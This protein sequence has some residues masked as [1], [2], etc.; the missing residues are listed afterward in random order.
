MED[1]VKALGLLCLGTRMKRLGERLQS[2]T[3]AIVD[4]VAS[5]ISAGQY[6]LFGAIDR[7][8]PLTIGELA[9]ALGVSQPGTTRTVN[10]LVVLGY[11]EIKPSVGDQRRKVVDLSVKGQALVDISKVEVWPKVESAVTDL[12]RGLEGPL[13]EQLAAIED[14]LEAESLSSRSRKTKP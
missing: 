12:C 4:A 10:Q 6:P 1:V 7:L 14:G 8:G 9:E 2:Q 11:L 5:D 3:Q 13:L